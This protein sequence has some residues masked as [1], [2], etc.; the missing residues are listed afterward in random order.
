MPLAARD[1]L[2]RY[3]EWTGRVCPL[4]QRNGSGSSFESIR[5]LRDLFASQFDL[6]AFDYR[7]TGSSVNP[8]AETPVGAGWPWATWY[9]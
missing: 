7:A 1:G 3:Y 2:E 9:R 4:L 8:T 6:P 5:P